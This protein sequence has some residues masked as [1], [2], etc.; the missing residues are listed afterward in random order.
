MWVQV[1]C[2]M[3]GC[4]S[5][6]RP[7]GVEAPQAVFVDARRP[8]QRV[9]AQRNQLAVG[10]QAFDRTGGRVRRGQR[11]AAVGRQR[12]GV[13][14]PEVVGGAPHRGDE[15]QQEASQGHQH[16]IA[17]G[18]EALFGAVGVGEV[19]P[20]GPELRAGPQALLHRLASQGVGA[21]RVELEQPVGKNG[22]VVGQ[23]GGAVLQEVAANG[24]QRV[25]GRELGRGSQVLGVQQLRRVRVETPH[26]VGIGVAAA[27]K[28][29]VVTRGTGRGH[30]TSPSEGHR[31][32]AGRRV[33]QRGMLASPAPHG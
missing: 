29:E 5:G 3:A 23:L 18:V 17:G 16:Q 6:G 7:C 9:I 25:R 28:N 1:P 2:W 33:G 22:V 4:A 20:V 31:H 10:L 30:G 8:L 12:V 27:A 24:H 15:V 21:L 32:R 14:V 19:G 13:E 26:L 11:V